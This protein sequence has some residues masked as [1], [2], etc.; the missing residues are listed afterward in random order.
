M[1][2]FCISFFSILFFTQ[3][4]FA[5]VKID[6]TRGNLEPLPTA[7]S[8]F[9]IE[10]PSKFSEE[11]KK[12]KLEEKISETISNNLKRS[13]LFLL[14]IQSLTFNHPTLHM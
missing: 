2:K 9:Y 3:A 5:L 1:K 10:D 13:G 8:K 12:L 14:L 7:V 11:L 6:I 4:S